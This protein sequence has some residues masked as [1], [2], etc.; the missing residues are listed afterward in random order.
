MG[1]YAGRGAD[2]QPW[3]AGAEINRDASLRLEYLAGLSLWMV[4]ADAIFR[5]IVAYRRYPADMLT[6]DAAYK[7]D[8]LQRLG[9]PKSAEIA[10]SDQPTARFPPFLLGS[11]AVR[12]GILLNRD[13]YHAQSKRP[14]REPRSGSA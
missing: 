11:P 7:D 9:L 14:T 13:S 3:L 12:Y 4:Q 6:N 5:E 2:L 10:D 1:Q 8:I